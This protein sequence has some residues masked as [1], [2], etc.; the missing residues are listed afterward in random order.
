MPLD[1]EILGYN[2]TFNSNLG[3]GTVAGYYA[4]TGCKTYN[5]AADRGC[6]QGV[7]L[8]HGRCEWVFHVI[9]FS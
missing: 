8:L 2:T 9:V 7:P 6:N 4:I 5:D 1:Q 3:S